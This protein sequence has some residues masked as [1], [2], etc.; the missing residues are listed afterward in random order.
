[1]LAGIAQVASQPKAK[2]GRRCGLSFTKAGTPPITANVKA[3]LGRVRNGL[4]LFGRQG[5]VYDRLEGNE[6]MPQH[7]L[8]QYSKKGGSSTCSIKMVKTPGSRTIGSRLGKKT[9]E[10]FMVSSKYVGPGGCSAFVLV[11]SGRSLSTIFI[12]EVIAV[13]RFIPDREYHLQ[14]PLW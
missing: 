1:M 8:G 7:I 4:D 12:S 11:S 10:I 14:T 9:S 3:M 2:R 5:K 13:Q 6:D